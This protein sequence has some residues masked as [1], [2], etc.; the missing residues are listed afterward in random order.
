MQLL[1]V[2][3]E[4]EV[5]NQADLAD[6]HGEERDPTAAARPL[7]GLLGLFGCGIHLID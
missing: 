4:D 1:E 2:A 5:E 7:V 6:Q 3:E